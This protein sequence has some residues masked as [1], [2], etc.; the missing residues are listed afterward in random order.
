[1]AK[2]WENVQECREGMQQI[3]LALSDYHNRRGG[4]VYGMTTDGVWH[5]IRSRRSE[6]AFP[7]AGT[8][9]GN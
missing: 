8:A 7:K 4:P 9:R 2:H 5:E 6:R 3:R 1:M